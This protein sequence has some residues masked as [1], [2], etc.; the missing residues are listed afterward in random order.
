MISNTEIFLLNMYIYINISV[1]VTNISPLKSTTSIIYQPGLVLTGSVKY[2]PL[3][4]EQNGTFENN[5]SLL[6]LFHWY[7]T[8]TVSHGY[9][10][11]SIQDCNVNPIS[12]AMKCQICH[13]HNWC[14]VM[15]YNC[16]FRSFELKLLDLSE[17]VCVRHGSLKMRRRNILLLY[18]YEE[19]Q[20]N[21]H[22]N[23]FIQIF[24]THQ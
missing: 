14:H 1:K 24:I 19:G 15:I 20:D 10:C 2:F 3:T 18:S 9:I 4:E 7:L 16:Q 6:R 12:I 5:F 17:E 22:K 8:L 11:F 23:I 13:Q 21:G